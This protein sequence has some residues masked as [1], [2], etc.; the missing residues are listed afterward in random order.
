MFIHTRAILSCRIFGPC[1]SV[2]VPLSHDRGLHWSTN[3]I[4]HVWPQIST[5]RPPPFIE[6]LIWS[7]Q[8]CFIKLIQ[9]CTLKLS[10]TQSSF[11]THWPGPLVVV[12]FATRVG[13]LDYTLDLQ[14]FQSI[15]SLLVHLF[16]KWNCPTTIPYL[17]AVA[18]W[19][20]GLRR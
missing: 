16:N 8:S 14:C 7:P 9:D 13:P 12:P 19:W 2:R 3:S 5:G 6:G 10:I 4:L 20:R 11:G 1:S 15:N 17:V 18:P